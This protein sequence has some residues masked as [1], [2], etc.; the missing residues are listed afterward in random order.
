MK[1]PTEERIKRLKER[2]YHRFGDRI[3]PNGDMYEDLQKFLKWAA[4]YDDGGLETRSALHHKQWLRLI[5]CPVITVD[6]TRTT[7]EN[8]KLLGV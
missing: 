2:E 3:L 4:G 8:L 7:N 6:G 1:T 5:T